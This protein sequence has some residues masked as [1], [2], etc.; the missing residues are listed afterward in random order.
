MSDW[1]KKP[2]RT[3]RRLPAACVLLVLV[4]GSVFLAGCSTNQ[5][6]HESTST[7]DGIREHADSAFDHLE[8]E[9]GAHQSPPEHPEP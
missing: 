1:H 8:R 5:S 2:W 3:S 6:G 9:E 4:S 7:R